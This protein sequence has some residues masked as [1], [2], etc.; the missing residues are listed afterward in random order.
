MFKHMPRG[1][2]R[3]SGEDSPEALA[4][5]LFAQKSTAGMIRNHPEFP[6]ART[7]FFAE[8]E[9]H[10]LSTFDTQIEYQSAGPEAGESL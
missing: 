9:G 10:C 4:L 6:T 3:Y 5:E 8:R 7:N 2:G 1:A